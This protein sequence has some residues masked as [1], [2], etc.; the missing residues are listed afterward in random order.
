MQSNVPRPHAAN[1]AVVVE[2]LSIDLCSRPAL[3]PGMDR[4]VKVNES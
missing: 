2:M 4:D 1:T 3:R